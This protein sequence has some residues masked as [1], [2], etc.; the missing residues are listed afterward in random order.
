MVHSAVWPHILLLLFVPCNVCVRQWSEPDSDQCHS[1]RQCE[2]NS[3]EPYRPQ[4]AIW[5]MRIPCWVLRPQTH[6]QNKRV[7]LTY[8]FSTV[9]MVARKHPN[10]TLYVHCLSCFYGI[11]NENNQS[12]TGFFVH[13]RIISAVKRVDFV[14]DRTSYVVLRGCWC[15]ILTLR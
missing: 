14:C 6:T 10:F 2:K 5:R 1:G 7:I 12:G 8:C 11:G 9:T 4:M 13:Q 15:D 3:V